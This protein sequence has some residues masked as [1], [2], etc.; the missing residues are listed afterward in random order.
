MPKTVYD[1]HD[2]LTEK[3]KS[4]YPDVSFHISCAGD[5]EDASLYFNDIAWISGPSVF[6]VAKNFKNVK[7]LELR[8]YES[9]SE[10][11]KL[12]K[13]A[14]EDNVEFSIDSRQFGLSERGYVIY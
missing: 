1:R 4:L 5:N 13:Q 3:F 12:K 11:E 8:R 7:N 10:I 2:E 14:I 9:F 6:D